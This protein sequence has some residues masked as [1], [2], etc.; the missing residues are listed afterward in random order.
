MTMSIKRVLAALLAA[1][2]ITACQDS[3]AGPEGQ[4]VVASPRSTMIPDAGLVTFNSASCTLGNA[5]TGAVSCNWDISN[6][7]EHSMNLWAEVFINASYDCVNPKNGRVASN[8]QREVRTLIQFFGVADPSLTGSNVAL[9]LP[10]LP[11]GNTGKNKK[12]NAC[13]GSNV[14]QSLTWDVNY[15]DVSVITVAGSPLMSCFASDNRDGCF[16]S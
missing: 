5:A 6:P 2:L 14:P 11:S 4:T 12:L 1:S 8:E 7:N 13:S 15:W 10:T 16:T 9:P 3:P